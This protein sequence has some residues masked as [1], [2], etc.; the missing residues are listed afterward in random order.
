MSGGKHDGRWETQYLHTNNQFQREC[1]GVFAKI[2]RGMRAAEAA[3]PTMQRMVTSLPEADVGC[4]CIEYHEVRE[5]G[6]LPDPRHH[7]IGSLLTVDVMLSDPA[8]DFGGGEFHT[9]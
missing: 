1:P 8:V 5:G 9:L 7:D 3:E 2:V 6:G 4:R